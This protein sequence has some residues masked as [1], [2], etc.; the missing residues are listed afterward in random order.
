MTRSPERAEFLGDIITTAVEGGTGYWAQVSQ[1]QYDYDGE[2]RLSVGQLVGQGT[3]AVLHEM[4]DAEDG[5]R[6]EGLVLDLDAVARGIGRVVR[7]ETD[8]ADRY[9]QRIAAADRLNDA[10]NLDAE[11]ADIIA[12][13]GLLGEVRYG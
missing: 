11:D 3:R 6:E 2:T 7:G 4:N 10:G 1:Y 8:V 5:Y 13:T 9:R 12:Q